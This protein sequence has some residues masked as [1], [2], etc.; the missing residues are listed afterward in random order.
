MGGMKGGVDTGAFYF[1]AVTCKQRHNE[2]SLPWQW[3]F[4][5]LGLLD[6]EMV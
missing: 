3:V 5:G 1:A 4:I 6:R 2:P